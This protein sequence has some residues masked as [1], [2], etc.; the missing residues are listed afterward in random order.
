M[1]QI[2]NTV[3][4]KNLLHFKLKALFEDKF[5]IPPLTKHLIKN[6]KCGTQ[7]HSNNL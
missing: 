1:N 5:G 7:K 3:S 2:E 4:K 6:Q